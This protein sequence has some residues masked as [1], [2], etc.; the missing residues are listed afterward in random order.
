VKFILLIN[1]YLTF[2]LA[3]TS[4]PPAAYGNFDG[5]SIP[6]SASNSPAV[7][8]AKMKIEIP[9]SSQLTNHPLTSP[10]FHSQEYVESFGLY[11]NNGHP[12]HTAATHSGGYHSDSEHHHSNE[13]NKQKDNTEQNSENVQ[14]NQASP[15]SNGSDKNTQS[16]NASTNDKDQVSANGTNDNLIKSNARSK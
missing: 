6:T 16:S 11:H 4:A 2:I 14:Q 7:T 5:R 15:Q 8:D 1:T 13:P 12:A 10:V 9:Q 3:S